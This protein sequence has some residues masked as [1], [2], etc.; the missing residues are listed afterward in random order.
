MFHAI[1]IRAALNIGIHKKYAL[2][3]PYTQDQRR[4]RQAYGYLRSAPH[5][6]WEVFCQWYHAISIIVV[7]KDAEPSNIGRSLSDAFR[8]CR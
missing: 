4:T 1:K 8:E 7:T 5:S 3:I 2:A 6:A